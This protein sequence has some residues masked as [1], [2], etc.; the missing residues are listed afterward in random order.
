MSSLGATGINGITLPASMDLHATNGSSP[1]A[2]LEL[3]D[4]VKRYPG[5]PPVDALAGVNLTVHGGELTAIVGPSGSGKSTLLNVIGLLDR[6]TSGSVRIADE[7]VAS[8]SDAELSALRARTIGFVFQQFHLVEGLRAID[9]VALGLLYRGV[10]RGERLDRART[11]LR[12]VGLDHRIDHRPSQ[13]SGGERQRVAVARAIVGEP[14]IVLADEPTGNLDSRTSAEIID[15]L[16]ALNAGG[17]TIVLITHDT[18]IADSMRRVV[19]IRDGR[20]VHDGSPA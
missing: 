19:A 7:D 20:I 18:A 3:V 17:S 6:A 8:T 14:A 15:L 13:L 9:N 1:P 16:R 2:V 4:V 10:P 11:A 12:S 5:T